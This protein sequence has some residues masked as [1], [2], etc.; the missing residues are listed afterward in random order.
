[1]RVIVFD[2]ETTNTFDEVGSSDP[3]YLDLAVV[4]IY[5]SETEEYS[6]YLKEDLQKLWPILEAA[7]ALVGFN[8]L[9]FDTPLLN[10]YYAGDLMQMKQIDLLVAV[11]DG[12]GRRLRLDTIAKATLGEA[13]SADGLQ[14]VRW[15]REGRQQEV[16]DYCIQDVKVTK[17]I[18]EYALEHKLLKYSDGA[19]VRDIPIDTS[20]WTAVTED[21]SAGLPPTLGF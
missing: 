9:H 1:M 3:A 7:D 14:A 5:D 8:S 4:C 15:W 13:K 12:L 6:S 18:Y 11:K 16:I 20:S 19:T 21:E 17:D 10:K 2:I